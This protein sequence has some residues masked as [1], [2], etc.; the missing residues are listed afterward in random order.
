[1]TNIDKQCSKP[2]H[3]LPDHQQIR[4]YLE[5]I[6]E[7]SDLLNILRRTDTS[8]KCLETVLIEEKNRAK[9]LL[10]EKR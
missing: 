9:S 6:S 2:Q 7:R 4:E 5:S 3:L 1:M 8:V 10:D